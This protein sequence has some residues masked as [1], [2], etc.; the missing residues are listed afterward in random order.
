MALTV[1]TILTG[2]GYTNL[3]SETMYALVSKWDAW[4]CGKTSFH[5]YSVYN[6][7]ST[8]KCVR[9]TL[10][11]AKHMAEDK[12]DLLLNEKVSV[13][14]QNGQ[15]ALNEVLSENDFYTQG[16][17]LVEKGQALGTAAF[18]EYLETDALGETKIKID[19]IDD[20][21]RIWPLSWNKG[22]ITECAFVSTATDRTL[23][24]LYYISMHLLES[25]GYVVKNV[26]YTENGEPVEVEGLVPE[27]KS[28]SKVPT[29]QIYKP[30][31]ANNF[32]EDSPLGISIY[33]N[34]ID[35]M[36]TLD[37]IFDSYFN[38]FILGRKRIFLDAT[39]LNMD[40]SP[41]GTGEVKPVFDP[42]DAVFYNLPGMEPDKSKPIVESNMTLRVE[43]HQKGIQD[44]LD[45]LSEQCGFGKGYYRFTLE[46]VQTAT[47]VISQNSKLYRKIRKDEILLR[48]VLTGVSRAILL[49]L[50]DD[51]LQD[52]SVIFDDSIIEDTN[53]KVNR[54]LLEYGQ[55]V[56]DRVM[57]F[58]ETRG[59]SLPAATK[60]V[61][62]IVKREQDAGLN[63]Q[64]QNI[65]PNPNP[66]E[67]E[68]PEDSEAM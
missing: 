15:D 30:N 62:E 67:D 58:M 20:P 49:L 6:G 48:N 12:A 55:G 33:A 7:K 43:E 54:S 24:K 34:S 21:R 53:T 14:V 63:P 31:I 9:K 28:K 60:L 68:N 41:D 39:I 3:P 23:G 2:L 66:K 61:Q 57:Y 52:I 27:W 35:T 16:N 4:Y 51:P 45:L 50:N 11:M 18:V 29:F 5:V 37:A 42:N 32:E 56:I 17:Q 25:D 38:E 26:A 40:V 44:T 47:G 36:K 10:R 59:L 13:V 22:T 64:E 46:N 19:Y 8:Q 65:N 1:R